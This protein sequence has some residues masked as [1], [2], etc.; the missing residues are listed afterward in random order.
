MVCPPVWGLDKCLKISHHRK[1]KIKLCCT[2][3]LTW[4]DTLEH[5][6][7]W[8][9]NMRFRTWNVRSLYNTDLNTKLTREVAKYKSNAGVLQVRED[10]GGTETTENY[11]FFYKNGK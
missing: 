9:T 1:G 5:L 4:T 3:P 8:K 10:K 7:K 2:K 6:K 11:T